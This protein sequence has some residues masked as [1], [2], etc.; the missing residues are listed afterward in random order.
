MLHE[1]EEY[2]HES[3]AQKVQAAK[4]HSKRR[5]MKDGNCASSFFFWVVTEKRKRENITLILNACTVGFA[6][7]YFEERVKRMEGFLRQLQPAISNTQALQLQRPFSKAEIKE[8]V[9]CMA[10]NQCNTIPKWIQ[11]QKLWPTKIYTT[12]LPPGILALCCHHGPIA[13]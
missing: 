5:W 1:V 2:L 12:R 3:E 11:L 13:S 4:V 10:P 9:R 8:I 6:S 7:K